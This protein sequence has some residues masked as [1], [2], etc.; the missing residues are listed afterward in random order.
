MTSETQAETGKQRATRPAQR[1][2]DAP[3]EID[4]TGTFHRGTAAAAHKRPHGRGE[5]GWPWKDG[6]EQAGGGE[7]RFV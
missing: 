3:Y 6:K 4:R 5:Q 7:Q 1:P 2:F